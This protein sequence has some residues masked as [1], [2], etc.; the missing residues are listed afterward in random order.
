MV[1][2][3]AGATGLAGV[4]A[5]A[6]ACGAGVGRGRGCARSAQKEVEQRFRK[7]GEEKAVAGAQFCHPVVVAQMRK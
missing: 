1:I 3:S 2:V 6:V 4:R 5:V 7:V